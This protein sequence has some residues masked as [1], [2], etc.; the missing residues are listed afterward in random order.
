VDAQ[1]TGEEGGAA[2]VQQRP[3]AP[4]ERSGEGGK[5]GHTPARRWSMA[6]GI[7]LRA[8]GRGLRPS[9]M[10]VARDSVQIGP[11]RQSAQRRIGQ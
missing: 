11:N 9:H 7:G 10:S 4:E 3:S 1:K 8:T 2:K 6:A 5:S